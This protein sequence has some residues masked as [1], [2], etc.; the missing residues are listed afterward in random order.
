MSL[1]CSVS[2]APKAVQ[3]TS[4]LYGPRGAGVGQLTARQRFSLCC[5]L[6]HCSV[7]VQAQ[8]VPMVCQQL[9]I[10]TQPRD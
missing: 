10:C 4:S 9:A 3:A 2:A 7:N 5:S 6:E 8:L 1:F